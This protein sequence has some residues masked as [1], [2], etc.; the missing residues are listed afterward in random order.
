MARPK[1][2]EAATEE[3]PQAEVQ[4]SA[5]PE[6]V[7]VVSKFDRFVDLVKD[8]EITHTPTTVEMHPWLQAQVDAGLVILC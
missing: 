6:T 4:H 8:V 7:E 1:K 2:I 3:E 5:S